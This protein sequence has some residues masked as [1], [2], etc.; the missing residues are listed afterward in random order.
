MAWGWMIHD[1]TTFLPSFDHGTFRSKFCLAFP[2][3][4]CHHET[5]LA[6]AE[7]GVAGNGRMV[8]GLMVG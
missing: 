2:G 8:D 5:S 7:L 6:G 1:D 3:R 4:K